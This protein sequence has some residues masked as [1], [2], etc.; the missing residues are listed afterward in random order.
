MF[1]DLQYSEDKRY[2]YDGYVEFKPKYVQDT[3]L[4]AKPIRFRSEASS[5][6]LPKWDEAKLSQIA[7]KFKIE[8]SGQ[9]G[10]LFSTQKSGRFFAIV[11]VDGYTEVVLSP[12]LLLPNDPAHLPTDRYQ[13]L[14]PFP[15]NR[16][17]DGK[18]HKLELLSIENSIAT[19]VLDDGQD[20][21]FRINKNDYWTEESD[22]VFGRNPDIN[23]QS[24]EL[25]RSFKG[26]LKS[27]F[28]NNKQIDWSNRGLL[29]NIEGG[30]YNDKYDSSLLSFVQNSV[31]SSK[32]VTLDGEGCLKYTPTRNPSSESLEFLFKTTDDRSALFQSSGSDI[33]IHIQGPSVVIRNNNANINTLIIERG[34]AFNDGNWHKL[35]ISKRDYQVE[36]SL[37][38]KYKQTIRLNRPTFLGSFYVGCLRSK[39]NADLK[40]FKGEISGLVYSNDQTQEDLIDSLSRPDTN[41]L[42]DGGL[43]WKS[44]NGARDGSQTEPVT[45]RNANSFVHIENV[46]FGRNAKRDVRSSRVAR[47][48]FQ[49]KTRESNGLLALLSSNFGLN[50]KPSYLAVEIVD[51][52]PYLISNI[53]NQLKR[54]SCSSER[55][56]DNNWHLIE[57]KRDR[58]GDAGSNG[59]SSTLTLQCDNQFRRFEVSEDTIQGQFVIGNAISV[60]SRLPEQLW[61]SR[62]SQF[63]GCI[64]DL[65]IAGNAI[66][67]YSSTT[68]ASRVTIERGCQDDASTCASQ[69]RC[70]NGGSCVEGF[71][72]TYCNC[73]ATSF[74]GAYC[75]QVASVLSFN[76]SYGIE[77]N[78][79]SLYSSTSEQISLRFKTRLRSGFLF[80]LKR[81]NDRA[82]L[83]LAVEDG[84]VKA[85]YDCGRSDKVIYVGDTNLYSNNNWNTVRLTRSGTRVLLEVIDKDRNKQF[86]E[87]EL[88]KACSQ[89]DYNT[90]VI[91]STRSQRLIH[92]YPNLIGFIQNLQFNGDDL[93]KYYI[94]GL[95]R[96]K[97]Q[98]HG[99]AD[100]GESTLLLHH[101]V[102]FREGCPITL[103]E[104]HSNERLNIH[105]LFKTTESNGVIFFRRGRDFFPYMILELVEGSLKFSFDFGGGLN[106]LKCDNVQNLNDKNWHAVTIRR[107]DKTKFSM[108]IDDTEEL[109]IVDSSSNSRPL[110]DLESF[111]IGGIPTENHYLVKDVITNPKNYVG[112]LASLEINGEVPDLLHES[113]YICP[114]LQYGCTDFT[115]SP[116]PCHNNGLCSITGN[117]LGCDCSM[118]SFTGPYCKD[119]SKFFSFGG[120]S[121]QCGM[122]RYNFVPPMQNLASDR[123]A[124]GFYTS[125]PDGLLTRIESEKGDQYID[126][127][128]VDGSPL[129]TVKFDGEAELKKYS[130]SKKFNDN[131]YHIFQLNRDRN[132]I[133]FRV[134][135]FE[136]DEFLI[137]SNDAVFKSQAYVYAGAYYGASNTYDNCYYGFVSGMMLNGIRVL[138]LGSL[139]G[140]VLV[141]QRPADT[142]LLNI[143]TTLINGACPIGYKQ[144]ETICFYVGCPLYSEFQSMFTCRCITGYYLHEDKCVE[145][146]P[147]DPV[148]PAPI[149]VP[150]TKLILAPTA[151]VAETPLGVIL[152][153]ISAIG[154]GLLAAAIA[155]RKC[156][157]GACVPARAYTK[158]PIHVT[159]AQ[160]FARVV[161]GTVSNN[162]EAL[163]K[164]E[165]PAERQDL[166]SSEVINQEE[167]IQ[168]GGHDVLDFGYAQEPI[169]TQ[170]VNETMEMFEQTTSHRDAGAA[171]AHNFASSAAGHHA[172]HRDLAMDSI[173]YS[174]NATDYEL[175]NVTCVTMTPNGKYAIIGQSIGTPQIW[176]TT[177]GQL[178]RAMNGSAN[179]CANI[180]LACNGTLLVGLSSDAAVVENH[181]LN[182]QLWEVQSGRPI[183]LNHQ[184][185]CCVFALSADTNSIFMAGNQRFGRGISVGILDLVTNELVKEIKSD[186]NIS[187]GEGPES[188][189][190]TPDEK[191]A[192]V[193]CK[194]I[195]GTNFV[196][197]DLT[198]TTE[199]AQTRSIALDAE[200]KCIQVLNNNEV[201]TGTRGGHIVQWNIHSCKPTVTF[202]DP[203]ENRAHNSS[204]N[205][206]I[207]SPDKEY[208][209]SASTD[210][211]A[212]VWNTNTKQLVSIMA[213]HS[214]EVCITSYKEFF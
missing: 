138:E 147:L 139:T 27:V 167:F 148:P 82:G 198:K 31:D 113:R 210:G 205:Q 161:S 146:P 94:D 168:Q 96:D 10:I 53:A 143:T 102:T 37:D 195:S 58:L 121:K 87:D 17:N 142:N 46:G 41:L 95:N 200:A 61:V 67:V 25:D 54:V 193:G 49:F 144:D 140:D 165:V 33:Y 126:V 115:C 197:F 50:D 106:I 177:S 43:G 132:K 72:R 194:S 64:K 114:T 188:I 21:K 158:V 107:I 60:F 175:S 80:A 178:I 34:I 13:R 179:S 110:T 119:D 145:E 12:H 86:V 176:D 7:F 56:N 162:A 38:D 74:N 26:C 44:R 24:N 83:V 36:I 19:I 89:V 201:L 116:N 183:A 66:D 190:I 75:D 208:L 135:N 48:A 35:R 130:V 57:I 133:T 123:L 207:L 3:L 169:V 16:V 101:Q 164:R 103:A 2:K 81:S 157:D 118:T 185:K 65:V 120:Q 163:I 154:L 77:Y 14:F 1:D 85:T 42:V 98:L 88:S 204:V 23:T 180:T 199:I 125:N 173:F 171:Y 52:I 9:N 73:D 99:Y 170:S 127:K 108:K 213:G 90:I 59:V 160:A 136:Q 76:G 97:W 112:C 105:L 91:G 186:P 166:M 152:G 70:L 45:L 153:V 71:S 174:Q 156:A 182:L 122:I 20:S 191:H 202:V 78:S 203:N 184:I 28:V 141:T 137:T 55:L 150:S 187:F 155:A 15:K 100:I 47:I 62:S 93:L 5:A 196:V 129:I 212:K 92:E 63:L 84:R 117:Q 192:I 18:W 211:T 209:A 30:C 22:I 134:D 172:S 149:K 159:P 40:D 79:D 69:S 6:K 181:A 151:G 189:V 68:G 214:G 32:V 131:N 124:F 51:G 4:D 29:N 11:I 109:S 111:I 39:I 206:L 104:V 8:K 128:L